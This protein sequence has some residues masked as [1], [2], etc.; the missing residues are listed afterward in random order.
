VIYKVHAFVHVG[1]NE[2]IGK[3][4]GTLGSYEDVSDLLKN[5][6]HALDN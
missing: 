5:V 2:N 3:E 1:V 4:R 6:S